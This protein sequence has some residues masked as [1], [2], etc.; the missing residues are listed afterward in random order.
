MG[1]WS[2]LGRYGG[3]ARV[4]IFALSI[5]GAALAEV[6]S[7][8]A[9]PPAPSSTVELAITPPGGSNQQAI[10]P[11]AATAEQPSASA[12]TPTSSRGADAASPPA[13][14]RSAADQTVTAAIPP[15]ETPRQPLD[16]VGPAR[17]EAEATPSGSSAPPPSDATPSEK[18]PAMDDEKPADSSAAPANEGDQ[19]P[20]DSAAPARSETATPAA[21][22]EQPPAD[23]MVAA[24]REK[25]KDPAL[26]KSTTS[27]DLA[28]LEAFYAE[29]TGPP[30]WITPMGFSTRAQGVINEIQDADDWGLASEAFD[31]PPAAD[32]PATTEAQAADEIKLDVAVLKYARFARGGRMT[33]SR[34][35]DVFDQ[36]A[37]LRSP[38]TVLTE[39]ADATAPDAYLRSLQ[40]KQEQFDRLHQALVKLR[41]SL[42]ARGRKPASDPVVQRIVINMER[43]RWMPPELGSYYVWDNIP[44]FTARVMKNGKSIYVEKVVV[45]QVKYATPIFSA[46]MRSIAFNPEWIV[47]E[48]IKLDDLQPSLRGGGVFGEPDTSILREHQLSVSYQGKPVDASTVDWGR[49]NIL[50]YTFTQPPGPENVLGKLKFNFPN[51]HAIYMHDT[52]QPEFFDEEVR[53]LSHGCI[54]VRQPDRLATLLLSEDK[55]WSAEQ[56]RNLLATGNNSIVPLSRS[57]PVH[58]TYFTVVADEKG[59]L[60]TFDDIYGIDAKMSA[61]M[62][63]KALKPDDGTVEAMAAAGPPKK[64]AAWNNGGGGLADA[65]NGLFGN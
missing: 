56:V 9:Q 4:A 18:P 62:F 39:I 51:R 49:A 36:K 16:S 50:Q 42:K 46:H 64:R 41:A 33:P 48:T 38:K 34:V 57:V 55:G 45:G 35:S 13:P 37:S 12:A 52:I 63:G 47:P 40:P 29:R 43:W 61:L 44:A 24:I 15:P 20:A 14:S 31:L 19:K 28:A 22:P 30:L 60:Q 65:I 6:V 21:L 23:P 58:L 1:G 2:L 3:M 11:A 17:A 53:A 10:T 59:K 32:L 5:V 25:L 26:R 8:G 7:S 54:R 27:D